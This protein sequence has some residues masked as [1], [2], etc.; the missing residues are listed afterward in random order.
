MFYKNIV[1][2]CLAWSGLGLLVTMSTDIISNNQLY[3]FC[4]FNLLF[5]LTYRV[6]ESRLR[7]MNSTSDDDLYDIYGGD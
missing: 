1:L 7:D 3:L 5:E 6:V 2:K 4:A